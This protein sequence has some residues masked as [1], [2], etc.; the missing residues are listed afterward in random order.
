M[1]QSKI[2]CSAA[3][4][5]GTTIALAIAAPTAHAQTTIPSTG[6]FSGTFISTQID[7]NADGLNAL[8]Q[9]VRLLTGALG[10]STI[11]GLNEFSVAGPGICP[12]GNPGTLF[13]QL[14][15]PAPAGL[16]QRFDQTGDLLIMTQTS[17]SACLDGTTGVLL[18]QAA[19]VIAGGS[20]SLAG[21]TGTFNLTGQATFLFFDLV[22]AFGPQT[23]TLDQTIVLP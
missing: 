5:L 6:T 10:A 1:I 14:V 15:A 13:T 22:D 18:T 2:L 16:V 11:D 21:A 23:G 12:T 9:N 4:A 19:G 17:G 7:S 8:K 3:A 20:G